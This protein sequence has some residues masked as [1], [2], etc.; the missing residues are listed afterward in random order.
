MALPLLPHQEAAGLIPAGSDTFCIGY[1]SAVSCVRMR[2][3]ARVRIGK[4]LSTNHQDNAS[5]EPP[6][7]CYP[8]GSNLNPDIRHSV[9]NRPYLRFWPKV[10]A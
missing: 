8:S 10:H 9:P 4:H 3:P 7:F 5:Q 2:K 1:T 6:I